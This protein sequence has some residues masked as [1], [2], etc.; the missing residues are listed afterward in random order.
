MPWPSAKKAA[1]LDKEEP[2]KFEDSPKNHFPKSSISLK[3]LRESLHRA[4]AMAITAWM[5]KLLC[6]M[7]PVK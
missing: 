4:M 7:M 2:V 6:A 5:T 3:P 1:A